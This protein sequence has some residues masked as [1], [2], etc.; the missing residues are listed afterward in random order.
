MINL[1][2]LQRK[3]LWS[4][5]SCAVIV[6]GTGEGTTALNAFDSALCAAGIGDFNLVKV[7]SILPPGATVYSI[8]NGGAELIAGLPKGILLPT[9]YGSIISRSS[10]TSIASAVGIAVPHESRYVGTI[11]E[12]S[13]LGKQHEAEELVGRMLKESLASR[14]IEEYEIILSSSEASVRNEAVCV[15]SAAILLA[16]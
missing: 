5:P 13:V 16:I 1:E 4:L 2:I 8:A 11:F 6:S 12:A 7:S 3:T 15:L 9:V 10:D 14:K